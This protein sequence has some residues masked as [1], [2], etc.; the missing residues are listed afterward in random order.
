MF[1][2]KTKQ[3]PCITD[4]CAIA[5]LTYVQDYVQISRVRG[6]AR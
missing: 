2:N 6:L 4:I 3:Q 1:Q 5:I